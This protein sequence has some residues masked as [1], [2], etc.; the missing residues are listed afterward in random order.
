MAFGLSPDGFNRKRLAD[1]KTELEDA[2]R[3]I[4]G[5]NIDVSPDR[6]WETHQVIIQKPS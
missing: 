1:I 4:F 6:D 3:L 5:D 2:Y